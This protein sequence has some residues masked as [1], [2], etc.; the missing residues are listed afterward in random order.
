[1]WFLSEEENEAAMEVMPTLDDWEDEHGSGVRYEDF[2]MWVKMVC[3]E[4]M[5]V[6]VMANVIKKIIDS[7]LPMKKGSNQNFQ[8]FWVQQLHK[9]QIIL[10][11][12]DSLSKD[13]RK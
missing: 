10:K 8:R 13:S 5:D 11:I 2:V 3:D 6:E 1:M 9:H 12:W 4:L 7:V